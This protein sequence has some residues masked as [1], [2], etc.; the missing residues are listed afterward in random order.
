[1]LFEDLLSQEEKREG[2]L[3]FPRHIASSTPLKYSPKESDG[4][5]ERASESYGHYS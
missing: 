1:M 3:C 4:P 5:K 2:F